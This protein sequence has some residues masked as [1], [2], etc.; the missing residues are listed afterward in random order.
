MSKVSKDVGSIAGIVAG[1]RVIAGSV[2]LP[3]DH[4]KEIRDKLI[5]LHSDTYGAAS[6]YDN[7]VILVGYVAFFTLWAGVNGDLSPLSRLT[8][9]ALMGASLMLYMTWHIL[10]MLTRQRYEFKCAAAARLTDQPALF[11]EAWVKAA[12]EH[13]LAAIRLLRFWPWIFVPS[14]AL[15][16]LAGGVLSYNALAVI[17]GWPELR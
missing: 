4:Q 12:Q 10:Q 13:Q 8:T 14:V 2:G 17:L 16:F 3:A 1:G 5:K 11:N 9:V 15:G 6:A 7:G